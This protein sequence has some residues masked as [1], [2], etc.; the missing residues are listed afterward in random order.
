MGMLFSGWIDRFSYRIDYSA[1]WLMC[2]V[3][4][5]DRLMVC[6]PTPVPV[7][8]AAE[9]RERRSKGT[10]DRGRILR[11][12]N[13]NTAAPK[14]CFIPN[15]GTSRNHSSTGF[16]EVN[17]GRRI[18]CSIERALWDWAGKIT[19]LHDILSPGM[20]GILY[21]TIEDHGTSHPRYADKHVLGIVAGIF[22]L[23]GPPE[24]KFD[25]DAE[26]RRFDL[27][28]VHYLEHNGDLV[29]EWF[30]EEEAE[31]SDWA[32]LQ[33]RE[34]VKAAFRAKRGAAIH[35]RGYETGRMYL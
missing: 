21:K 15:F 9:R 18:Q 12:I 31:T 17:P 27:D 32:D 22:H 29:A 1:L 33:M 23:E 26:I 4:H 3:F 28:A 6:Y 5:C 25:P 20:P 35:T 30:T 24:V 34:V 8:E 2:L 16:D 7:D 19:M 11:S 13:G 10:S 14:E